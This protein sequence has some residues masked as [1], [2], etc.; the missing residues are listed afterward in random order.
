[1][2]IRGSKFLACLVR[3]DL[4]DVPG[5]FWVAKGDYTQGAN[6]VFSMPMACSEH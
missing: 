2:F 3:A 5:G 6:D 1:M 4:T